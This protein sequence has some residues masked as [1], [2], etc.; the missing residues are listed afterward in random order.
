METK[1]KRSNNPNG[2]PVGSVNK[3]NIELKTWIASLIDKNR[4]QLETDLKA[5]EP[6]ER[7]QI[8]ER[9]MQYTTPK[10][11]SVEAHLELEKLTDQQITE[12]AENILK[13]IENDKN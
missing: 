5:M 6:R 7:W 12:L 8:I 3:V 1:R 2:R 4:V 9:L 11:Q 13:N 10:M